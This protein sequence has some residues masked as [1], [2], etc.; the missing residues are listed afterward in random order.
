MKDLFS[1]DIG[2]EGSKAKKCIG[3]LLALCS[4]LSWLIWFRGSVGILLLVVLFAA[5][6]VAVGF[7]KLRARTDKAAVFLNAVW[8]VAYIIAVSAACL[9]ANL[10]SEGLYR[11]LLNL[12]CAFIVAACFFTVTA[13]WRASINLAATVLFLLICTNTVVYAF[14]GKGFWIPLVG[15]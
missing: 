15:G 9:P 3:V 7:L 6:F 11:I 1:L 13:R 5:A 2:F 4:L 8:G 14:R 12:L 10:S